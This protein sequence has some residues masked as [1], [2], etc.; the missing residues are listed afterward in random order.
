ML[1][2]AAIVHTLRGMNKITL[3]L[4]VLMLAGC[5]GDGPGILG[6]GNSA[7]DTEKP[8]DTTKPDG[9]GT[10]S[11]AADE[12]DTDT[13]TQEA[14]ETTAPPPAD[15]ARTV[16]EFDTTTPEERAEAAAPAPEPA[17]TPAPEAAGDGRLGTTVASIGAADEPGFW[18]KTPLVS[19]GGSGR[20]FYPASGR[21]VQVQLIPSGGSSGAGSQV[22]LAA[23]RLLD[24]P[25][26]G[27]PE[28]VVYRN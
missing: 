22:S 9:E 11:D 19:E 2:A 21:T 12:P 25:L 17:P 7:P 13:R 20:L 1:N 6:G 8:S 18:I 15:T 27:L 23:L 24:A 16:E 14:P 10:G 4:T 3:L 5:A 26:D 28:L